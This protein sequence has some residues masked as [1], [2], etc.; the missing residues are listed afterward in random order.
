MMKSI[1]AIFVAQVVIAVSVVLGMS[2]YID[3]QATKSR[4]SAELESDV[5]NATNRMSLSLPKV[6]W[7]YDFESAT[8]TISAELKAPDIKAV[9]VTNTQGET[10]MFLAPSGSGADIEAA[11]VSPQDQ[12]RYEAMQFKEHELIFVEYGEENIVGTLQVF[13]NTERLEQALVNSLWRNI[14][15][16]LVLDSAMIIFLILALTTTVLKPLGELTSRIADLAS[17]DGDLSKVIPAPR[18]SEFS[19]ITENINIFTKSLREIVIDVSDASVTLKDMAE[20]SGDMAR[21][22][23]NRLG[24]QKHSLS[25][26]AAAATEMGQSIS[27]VA[28]TANDAATQAGDAANLIHLVYQTIDSSASDIINMRQEMERVNTEMHKL[29]EEGEKIST[30]VNVIDD[31]SEQTNLLALNAA[32]EAARAGEHGRGF[33]VVADEVRN[34]SVKTRD[35]TEQIQ[36]NIHSLSSATESVEQEINRIASLLE[37]TANRVSE[38]QHSVQQ[39]KL[40]IT[41]ISERSGQISQ[42]TDE[43]RQAINEVSRAIVEASEATNEVSA[44][45]Q[46]NASRTDQ[47]LQ[48]S[49]EIKSQMCKF[50]T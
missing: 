21:R 33:A 20:A 23:A 11:A 38:S 42:A 25:T 18:Y 2:S 37:S 35:S 16:L 5:Y 1:K 15:E 30:V 24:Q 6:V 45:A 10:V 47:V 49:S 44:G 48:L 12:S 13:Y 31:I 41:D 29:L 27:N 9:K 36:N 14:I 40:S 34:L 19:Q 50:K 8:L 32:I 4:L 43:Q 46:E 39:V 3:Y 26:V 28:D 7:G 22:N 17:G